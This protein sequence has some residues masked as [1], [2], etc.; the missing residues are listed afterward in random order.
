MNLV[1]DCDTCAKQHTDACDGCVVTFLV[2]REPDDAVIFDV[3]A[4]A[5]IKRLQRA[6]L[7]ADLQH[8]LPPA[9]GSLDPTG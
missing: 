7:V 2:S 3:M 8:Q 6:G 4:Y 9:T 5:A 1:I